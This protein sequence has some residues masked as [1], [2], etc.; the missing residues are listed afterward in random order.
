M[1]DA[2]IHHRIQLQ[3]HSRRE[4]AVVLELMGREDARLVQLLRTRLP[5]A[6]AGQ[7]SGL[8]AEVRGLRREGFGRVRSLIG[9][10]MRALARVEGEA[11]AKM[12]IGAIG[13]PVTF[14]PVRAAQLRNAV[15]EQIFGGGAHGPGRTLAGWLATI[16]EADR[17]RLFAAVDL[18]VRKRETIDDQVRRIAGTRAAGYADGVLAV[19]RR[20]AESLTRTA[21]VHAANAAQKEWA[22]ANADVVTGLEQV[23]VL[24]ERTCEECEELNGKIWGVDDDQVVPV[25][26]QC[27]GTLVPIF[28]LDALAD[29]V[30]D[31]PADAADEQERAA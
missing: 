20:Q 6:A 27:R 12:A 9:N 8:L 31:A 1:R 11:I 30:P 15:A 7:T 25:H 3:R 24:D 2:V 23:E 5:R 29:K 17:V 4:A 14:N 18:G 28:D 22:A 13:V 16:A 21:V 19:S 26:L 10:D